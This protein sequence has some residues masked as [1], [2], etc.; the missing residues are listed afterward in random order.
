MRQKFKVGDTVECVEVSEKEAGIVAGAGW[1]KGKQFVIAK[2]V[3]G[4]ALA[5]CKAVDC[6]FPAKDSGVYEP[7]L[8]LI[9]VRQPPQPPRFI[10][11]Y[12]LDQ[13]P[14]ELFAT[15]KE[16]RARIKELAERAD[17]KRDSIKVYEIKNVRA[18]KLG[19]SIK[20]TK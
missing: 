5:N 4:L 6:C 7:H 20:F 8:R 9:K 1:S 10:L 16:V 3:E 18:V 11:Q 19:T 2:V 12:E 15:E 17:L 13:D 14:F